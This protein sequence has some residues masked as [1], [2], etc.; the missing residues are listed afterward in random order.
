MVIV[1]DLY[2]NTGYINRGAKGVYHNPL[3]AITQMA[4]T[5]YKLTFPEWLEAEKTQL[6]AVSAAV[7]PFTE[8]KLAGVSRRLGE[9]F[10]QDPLRPAYLAK[11]GMMR[12]DPRRLFPEAKSLI[13]LAVPFRKLPELPEPLPKAK[14]PE[15]A[16]LVAGYAARIDYHR[17]GQTLMR[18]LAD[19][20]QAFTGEQFWSSGS[21]DTKPLAE[22]PLAAA[23]GLGKIGLNSCLLCPGNGS[24]CFI[25]SLAVDCE[26]P[27]IIGDDFTLPCKGCGICRKSCPNG[28][29]G[30]GGMFKVERCASYI[31]QDVKG[32]LGEADTE[33]LGNWIFGCDICTAGCPESGLPDTFQLDLEWLL[34]SPA[35]EVKRKIAP[36]PMGHAG[37]TQLRRNALTVLGRRRTPN[38][39][40][41]V[42]SAG[43]KFRI[44][45]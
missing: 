33:L 6:G 41:L 3:E 36:T 38:A 31:S 10:S 8:A 37:V 44:N 30:E 27:E 23:A 39:V 45:F 21:V 13:F 14:N 5:K 12:R 17:H 25:T 18:Q 34:L 22:K 7:L 40:K 19:D 11:T 15:L 24:G 42:K 1:D 16:G 9:V 32:E 28:V 2:K 20:L 43:E 35:S 4:K 26:L 29:I